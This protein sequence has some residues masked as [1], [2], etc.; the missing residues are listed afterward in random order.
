MSQEN[1]ELVR[2]YAAAAVTSG[3]AVVSFFAPDIE[4]HLDSSHPDQRVLH[5]RQEVA[6]YFAGW[7]ATFDE[8]R[9]DVEDY[10]DCGEHVVMPFTVHG[11]P[12]G[13]TAEVQLT[14]TWNFKV[15]GGAIVEVR[16]YLDTDEALRA[17]RPAQ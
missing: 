1:V 2:A 17:V 11:R 13:S 6:E 3:V 15:D 12:R 14:E 7:T 16:E 8:I 5:G 10:L 4:W 9:L